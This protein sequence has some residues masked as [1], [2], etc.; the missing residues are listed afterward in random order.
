MF[1]HVANRKNPGHLLAVV[2]FP[3]QGRKNEVRGA[4]WCL[5]PSIL[6][7]LSTVPSIVLKSINLL[8]CCETA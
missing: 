8:L 2:I 4:G 6:L 5:D 1:E 7:M 3:V